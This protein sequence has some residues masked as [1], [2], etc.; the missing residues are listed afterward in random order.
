M[1]LVGSIG[2]GSR[3]GKQDVGILETAR[4][5]IDDHIVQHTG[6]HVLLVDIDIVALEP[7]IEYTFGYLALG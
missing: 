3:I 5:V 6:V 4:C 2:D 7:V 1:P